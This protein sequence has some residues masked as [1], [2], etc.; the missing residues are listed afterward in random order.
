MKARWLPIMILA[1]ILLIAIMGIVGAQ[2]LGKTPDMLVIDSKQYDTGCFSKSLSDECAK[3]GDVTLDA[4]LPDGTIKCSNDKEEHTSVA[5][6]ESFVSSCEKI[7][8][9]EVAK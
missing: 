9:E 2:I 6:K 1:G 4:V 8:A 5:I 3:T 7:D